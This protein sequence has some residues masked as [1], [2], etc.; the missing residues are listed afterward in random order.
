MQNK[1]LIILLAFNEENNIGKVIDDLTARY[2]KADILVVDDG[3]VDKTPEILQLKKVDFVRHIFNMG[4]GASFETGCLY[5]LT[6][7]YE[8]VV[9][10]DGD[11]QHGIDFIDAI[12]KPV[13]HG[14][15]DITIGSRFLGNSEFKTS[16]A[17]LI[18]IWVIV[19]ILT[20]L[21][22]RKVTDPTSGF[23]AMN[24]RAFR[25][26]SENCAYDYP[27]PEILLYHKEFRIKEIPVSITKR[28]GGV[29]SITPFR[30]IYYMI[31]VSI[32]LVAKSF[33]ERTKCPR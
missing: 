25:F 11:G 3:S 29:S 12:L 17:R 24:R 30:S 19:F 32:S 16:S 20:L 1:T 22:S 2:K 5:A 23:C 6:R 33:R 15:A 7:G 9:R 4:I 13:Q 18:G 26:F 31:K 21:T 8:Y 10:M 28:C 27:E 14:D